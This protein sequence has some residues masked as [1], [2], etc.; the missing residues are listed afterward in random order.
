MDVVMRAGTERTRI[1]RHIGR[2]ERSA[3]ERPHPTG[4]RGLVRKLLLDELARYRRARR[5]PRNTGDSFTPVFVDQAGTRC[6]MA[7]LMELG[8]AHELVDRIARTRNF[9]RIAKLADIPELVAWLD[10]SG[11]SVDEAAAIQPGY[12]PFCET[13]A[14]CLC[15]ARPGPSLPADGVIEAVV[16]APY[17][18]RV[19][20]LYGA[21]H[22]FDVGQ[23]LC[24]NETTIGA[25]VLV[26]TPFTSAGLVYDTQSAACPSM[27]VHVSVTL[28]NDRPLACSYDPIGR[29]PLTKAQ[30][31]AALESN[32][33]V[34]TLGAL[35]PR[36]QCGCIS[37]GV[38]G[39]AI[40]ACTPTSAS[41]SCA[42]SPRAES[43]ATI[44]ILIAIVSSL[45]A[46]KLAR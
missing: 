24:V 40:D 16:T 23:T 39:A 19:T 7:A 29:L 12:G 17:V 13:T 15:D 26:P 20:T 35:D 1:A 30:A 44:A 8:G 37:T 36:W 21:T 4:A 45:A 43:P 9:D 25:M 3:L 11:V 2:A 10:A 22:G 34:A 18:A 33:C 28:E 31:V 42:V 5:F 14:M 27:N 38:A 46:R 6:A 32:D 41:S